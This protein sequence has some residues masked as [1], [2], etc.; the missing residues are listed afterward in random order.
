VPASATMGVAVGSAPASAAASG[1]ELGDEGYRLF[2]YAEALYWT[3]ITAASVGYGDITPLTNTGRIIAA[4]LG[5]MGVVTIGVI[6]GLILRW[7]TPRS[8]D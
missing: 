8:I 5:V 6:A 2:T 7:I 1:V 3:I 4:T